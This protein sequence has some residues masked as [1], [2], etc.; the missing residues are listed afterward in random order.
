MHFAQLNVQYCQL[1]YQHL[2]AKS[3]SKKNKAD[4]SISHSSIKSL[5]SVQTCPM[6]IFHPQAHTENA[7]HL[8]QCVCFLSPRTVTSLSQTEARPPSCVCLARP[9]WIQASAR[10]QP[11]PNHFGAA[12]TGAKIFASLLIAGVEP[13]LSWQNHPTDCTVCFTLHGYE[14]V[15]QTFSLI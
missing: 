3:T 6:G 14:A 12:L 2:T 11:Q 9:L 1:A 5:L 8:C 4:S 13:S 15:I 7:G 10:V